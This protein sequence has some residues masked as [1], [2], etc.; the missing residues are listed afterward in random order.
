[1]SAWTDDIKKLVKAAISSDRYDLRPREHGVI[2][3]CTTCGSLINEISLTKLSEII[4][5][6]DE[7]ERLN[8]SRRN[9]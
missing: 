1:M 3:F 5:E 9:L 2:I 4:K 7:H 6:A 8:H